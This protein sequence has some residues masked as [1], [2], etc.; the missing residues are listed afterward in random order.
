[1]LSLPEAQRRAAF[2]D[3]LLCLCEHGA[4]DESRAASSSSQLVAS[5]A[6]RAAATANTLHCTLTPLP[7]PTPQ[8]HTSRVWLWLDAGVNM[9]G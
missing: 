5:A 8:P 9:S 3:F 4:R 1:M 6:L 2:L 7:S